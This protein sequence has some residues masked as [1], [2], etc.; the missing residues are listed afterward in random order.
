M[1]LITSPRLTMGLLE[2]L[3][4]LLREEVR[5]PI[6]V[7]AFHPIAS[8]MSSLCRR[9]GLASSRPNSLATVEGGLTGTIPGLRVTFG[10]DLRVQFRADHDHERADE[11]PGRQN[12]RRRHRSI[13]GLPVTGTFDVE[14]EERRGRRPDSGREGG[15][16][17]DGPP[18][19]DVSA[20][21]E[22]IEKREGSEEE[23]K[24]A[25]SGI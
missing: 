12:D 5:A 7:D 6:L 10:L 20:R 22:A 8:A 13:V 23:R 25:A 16:G 1:I 18:L 9:S 19:G 14:G 24:S 15:A 3:A 4:L 21:R 11:H 2:A 17:Q